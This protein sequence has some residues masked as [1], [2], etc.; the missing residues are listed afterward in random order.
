MALSNKFTRS[1][2]L[3]APFAHVEVFAAC[4]YHSTT[5]GAVILTDGLAEKEFGL[6]GTRC[7]RQYDVLVVASAAHSDMNISHGRSGGGGFILPRIIA[8]SRSICSI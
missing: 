4:H 1:N 6:F 2:F 8:A 5:V 7:G 3:Q